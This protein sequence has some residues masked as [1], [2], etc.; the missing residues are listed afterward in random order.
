MLRFVRPPVYVNTCIYTACPQHV[1]IYTQ[2][3]TR[4]W[5]PFQDNRKAKQKKNT[6]IQIH[7]HTHTSPPLS[8]PTS[9]SPSEPMGRV[10]VAPKNAVS[11]FNALCV[12]GCAEDI[13]IHMYMRIDTTRES[14]RGVCELPHSV[15]THTQRI[16]V[17]C[18]ENEAAEMYACGATYAG[19]HTLI[20]RIENGWVD[21]DKCFATPAV[22]PQVG[23]RVGI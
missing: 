14:L 8:E 1:Y 12:P 9:P 2:L 7:A 13:Y 20:Q 17:F 22:M 11:L 15:H 23:T 16:L 4:K 21:F 19:L 3:R 5:I 10:L 18:D 6:H